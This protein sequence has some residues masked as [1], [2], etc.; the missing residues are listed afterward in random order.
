M[1]LGLKEL[2]RA[3][4]GSWVVMVANNKWLPMEKKLRFEFLSTNHSRQSSWVVCRSFTIAINS[5]RSGI[6]LQLKYLQT[7]WWHQI[8]FCK[9]PLNTA[10]MRKIGRHFSGD[11]FRFNMYEYRLRFHWNLFLKVQLAI[12]QHW[13]RQWFGA[14]QATSHCLNQGWLVYAYMHRSASMSLSNK[15]VVS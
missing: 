1:S 10:R 8:C 4:S 3:M 9:P 11:V 15:Q 7:E 2:M 13:F 12:F 6:P 14:C 5:T